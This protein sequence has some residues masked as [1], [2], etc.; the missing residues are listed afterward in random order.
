[1]QDTFSAKFVKKN[2]TNLEV[3]DF[4]K[5]TPILLNV[6]CATLK[7]KTNKCWTFK[8][9]H[10]KFTNVKDVTIHTID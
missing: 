1:M 8:C 7:L 6:M 3:I 9:P 5:E 10:V 4:I 2:L